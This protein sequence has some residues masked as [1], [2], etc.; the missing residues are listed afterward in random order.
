VPDLIYVLATLML[1]GLA[2]AYVAGCD[3]LR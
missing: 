2:G 3:R 1:F